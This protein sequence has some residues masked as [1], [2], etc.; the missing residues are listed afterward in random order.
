MSGQYEKIYVVVWCLVGQ[1]VSLK[2][3]QIL[4]FGACPFSKPADEL[5]HFFFRLYVPLLF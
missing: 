1:A 5:V 3:V 2:F 4:Y